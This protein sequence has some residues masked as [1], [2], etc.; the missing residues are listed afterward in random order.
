MS[1]SF[2]FNW[3]R[4]C[5]AMLTRTA[6]RHACNPNTKQAWILCDVTTKVL[7]NC[8]IVWFFQ[9]YKLKSCC[10]VPESKTITKHTQ[11]IHVKRVEISKV[12]Y[13]VHIT[14]ITFTN[15]MI[16]ETLNWLNWTHQKNLVGSKVVLPKFILMCWK[17]VQKIPKLKPP[18]TLS[19]DN[20]FFWL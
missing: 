3:S 19:H 9:C 11:I 13:P 15:V 12:V 7:V 10:V 16:V 2:V 14:F 18:N 8:C 6:W 5:E 1:A 4:W 17:V 20:I